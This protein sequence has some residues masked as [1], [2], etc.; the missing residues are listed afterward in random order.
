[1]SRIVLCGGAGYIGTKLT[2]H[3][4]DNTNYN[5]VI[6]DR[7]DFRLDENFKKTRLS[8]DRVSFYQ[9]DIR[10]ILTY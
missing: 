7:L 9:K 6:V 4:L 10:Q 5:I 2:E 3:I 1:M 8:D